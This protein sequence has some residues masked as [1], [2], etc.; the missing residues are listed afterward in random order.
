[1]TDSTK[2][3]QNS[4]VNEDYKDIMNILI[5]VYEASAARIFR[6]VESRLGFEGADG[7]IVII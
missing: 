2:L 3:L 1:M 7:D 5:N 4:A 6:V